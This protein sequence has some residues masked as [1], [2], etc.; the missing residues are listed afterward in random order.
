[1]IVMLCNADVT[2][3]DEAHLTNVDERT[4]EPIFRCPCKGCT[5]ESYLNRGCPK[6]Y[7]PYLEMSRLSQNDKDNLTQILLTHIED[8]IERFSDLAISTSESLTDR[9]VTVEKL[10]NVVVQRDRSLCEKLRQATSIDMAFYILGEHWSFFNYEIL[11]FVIKRLGDENDKKN[12]ETYLEHFDNYCKHK[13]FEVPPGTC[14]HERYYDSHSKGDSQLFVVVAV[15][16][17]LVNIGDVKRAQHRLATLLGIDSA[18]LRVHRIDKGSVIL[19]VSVPE[20]VAKELFPLAKDK[21]TKLKAE[22]FDIFAPKQLRSDQV[23][24]TVE[25]V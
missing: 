5:L 16:S 10:K 6:S 11:A 1:M 9:N 13:I 15:E 24:V 18:Q 3:P 21:V 14:G 20:F 23:G 17:M 12:L 7:Y 8:I 19:V 22:G 25:H 4:S 2:I